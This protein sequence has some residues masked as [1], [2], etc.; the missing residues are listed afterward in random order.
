MERPL[1]ECSTNRG[2]DWN[3]GESDSA[4]LQM[5]E[6]VQACS[7]QRLRNFMAKLLKW[8]LSKYWK[9]TMLYFLPLV[10]KLLSYWSNTSV[11]YF[12]SRDIKHLFTRRA[13]LSL[14]FKRCATDFECCSI[15]SKKVEQFWIIFMKH[16]HFVLW[17][18]NCC[19]WLAI[20]LWIYRF[21]LFLLQREIE[22]IVAVAWNIFQPFLFGLIGAEVSITS[23][24]PETV[25]KIIYKLL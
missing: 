5:E 7:S 25:G 3:L 19:V 16:F 18:L 1:T 13:R 12:S 8:H 21:I 22:K 9:S 4:Q 23:L 20:F 24:R 2:R 15:R 10:C 14:T 17:L 6:H 11:F